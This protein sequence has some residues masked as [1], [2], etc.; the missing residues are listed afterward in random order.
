MTE[1]WKVF[2]PSRMLSS[3][4]GYIVGK[5][6]SHLHVVCVTG[7]QETILDKELEIKVLGY[8][9][10]KTTRRNKSR[11]QKFYGNS[12]INVSISGTGHIECTL[13]QNDGCHPVSVVIYN[14]QDLLQSY[15]LKSDNGLNQN[16][17]NIMSSNAN[18]VI[19]TLNVHQQIM[20][21]IKEFDHSCSFVQKM[22]QSI[23]EQCMTLAMRCIL[24]IINLLTFILGFW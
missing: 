19:Q 16:G 18:V 4:P 12:F 15:L 17:V 9:N 11:S 10:G 23:I 7:C 22:K 13:Y 24:K 3:P 20:A 5:V 1:L 2:V 6:H 21:A 8:W 14:P